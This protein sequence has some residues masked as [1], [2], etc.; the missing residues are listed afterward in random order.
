MSD[1]YS[2]TIAWKDDH[3]V[4]L[5]QF[6][7]I[8][9]FPIKIVIWVY[10]PCWRAIYFRNYFL[11]RFRFILDSYFLLFLLICF[12]ASPLFDFLASLLFLLLSLLLLCFSAFCFSCFSAFLLFCFCDFLILLFLFLQSCVFAALLLPAP[13]R[14][15]LLCFLSLPSLCFSFSF[16]SFSPVCIL[17]ETLERP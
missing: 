1:S 6:W 13:L 12:S 4:C 3:G 9:I 11:I 14:T 17:N 2:R 16:A 8:I 15:L 10:A 5:N 7:F